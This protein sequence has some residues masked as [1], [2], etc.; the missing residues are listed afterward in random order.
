MIQVTEL[1]PVEPLVITGEMLVGDIIPGFCCPGHDWTVT[2]IFPDANPLYTSV[3]GQCSNPNCNE[4]PG[5]MYQGVYRQL[6]EDIADWIA[7]ERRAVTMN[8]GVS[9]EIITLPCGVRVHV[10]RLHAES[11]VSYVVRIHGLDKNNR[12]DED[13]IYISKRRVFLA[14]KVT[15]GEVV[16]GVSSGDLLLS[17][18]DAFVELLQLAKAE[19]QRLEDAYPTGKEV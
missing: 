4:D 19:A 13:L 1:S 5:G 2:E 12:I 6:V 17:Q 16:I 11:T 15:L 9:K 18:V 7:A 8:T 10:S 14:G 3:W